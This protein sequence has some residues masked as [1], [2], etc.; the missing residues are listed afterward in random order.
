MI[1]IDPGPVQSAVVLYERGV[2]REHRTATN[3][4]VRGVLGLW[5]AVPGDVLVIEQIAS[6]GMAVGEEVFETCVWSGRFIEVWDHPDRKWARIKRHEIKM[7]LCGSTRA[8]DANVRQA[9]IDRFGGPH[10]TKKGGALYKVKGDEWQALAVAITWSDVY[11]RPSEA[12]LAGGAVGRR[13]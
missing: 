1:A 10:A 3:A 8:K 13:D 6:Y 11:G 9:L 7:H 4:V 12:A 2:V 5:G